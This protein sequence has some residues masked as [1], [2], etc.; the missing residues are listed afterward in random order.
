MLMGRIRDA[1]AGDTM[2][3]WGM[4]KD[5]SGKVNIDAFIQQND[6]D[7][8]AIEALRAAPGWVQQGVLDW[9]NL[10]SAQ[11]PSAALMARIKSLQSGQKGGGWGMDPWS[12]MMMSMMWDPWS[13]MGGKGG[14]G[15]KSG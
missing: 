10:T 12:T 2:A 5:A 3:A 8:R 13:A 4:M 1:N 14:K 6:L 7:D 11:K 9:G 15:G